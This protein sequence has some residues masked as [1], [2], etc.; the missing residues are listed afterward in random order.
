MFIK[1]TLKLMFII[2]TFTIYKM[3]VRKLELLIFK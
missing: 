3:I 1:L 2:L